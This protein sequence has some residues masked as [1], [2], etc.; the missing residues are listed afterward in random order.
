VLG[1]ALGLLT[2]DKMRSQ[3]IELHVHCNLI[4]TMQFDTRPCHKV[5]PHSA[6]HSAMPTM[7]LA[8]RYDSNSAMM[9]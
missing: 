7:R 5:S 9:S 2:D 8:E 6:C 1:S 4:E 3:A